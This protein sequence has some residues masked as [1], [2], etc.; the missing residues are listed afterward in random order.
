M[1]RLVSVK[2]DD[3]EAIL[4]HGESVIVDDRIVGTVM[5][6]AYGHTVGGAVGLAM[7]EAETVATDGT[8]VEVD[9]ADQMVEATLS[10]R[11][12]YDPSG[13]RMRA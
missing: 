9:A 4:L 1:T 7:V 2:L 3:P 8:T 13:S 11:A 6:A 12:L 10:T 5:S